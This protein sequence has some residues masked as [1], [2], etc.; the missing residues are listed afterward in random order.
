MRA[1]AK[2]KK[3]PYC[4]LLLSLNPRKTLL[5]LKE[6]AHTLHLQGKLQKVLEENQTMY[7][8]PR[9]WRQICHGL[10]PAPHPDVLA[11]AAK[12]ANRQAP[13]TK[14]AEAA[15]RPHLNSLAGWAKVFPRKT[16]D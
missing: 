5:L 8:P 3:Y 1:P 9:S 7:C 6:D 10:F 15:A 4:T 16:K 13:A 2:T 11:L 14:A 12:A